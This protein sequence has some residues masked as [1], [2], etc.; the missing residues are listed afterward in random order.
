M[1]DL[2]NA[3]EEVLKSVIRT[4]RCHDG[5]C[6]MV[7]FVVADVARCTDFCEKIDTG[8]LGELADVT[9]AIKNVIG[10]EGRLQRAPNKDAEH[11]KQR[12]P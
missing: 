8:L 5:E 1:P 6:V 4:V 11:P 9:G 3:N 12:L 10:V 2:W 7:C